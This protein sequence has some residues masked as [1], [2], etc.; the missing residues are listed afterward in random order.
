MTTTAPQGPSVVTPPDAATRLDLYRT[1][2]LARTFEEAIL[3]EYHA[4]KGPGFDIGKGLVP[5][6]MHLSAGQEPVAAGR[7]R[8]P[9]RRRRGHRDPPPAPLR[10]RPRRG[11]ATG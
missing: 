7:L 4:D 5:G 1:M 11:P 6:E 8:A 10:D 9:H 3:R 2:V